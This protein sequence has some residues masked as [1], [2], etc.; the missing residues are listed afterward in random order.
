MPTDRPLATGALVFALFAGLTALMFWPWLAHLSTAL[1]GPPEDNLQDFW[2]SWYAAAAPK[3]DGFFHTSMIRYPEGVSLNYHSFAYPQVALVVALTWLFG[4]DHAT[5]VALQNLTLL[6]S[7][8]MAG[9]GAY[10]LG[11]HFGVAPL[12]ALASGFV[13]AFNPSHVAHVMHHAHVSWIG[14]IPF[15]VLSYLIAL[16]RRSRAWLA[17]SAVLYALSALSCWYYFFYLLFFLVFHTI[18]L[19]VRD[20]AWPRGFGLAAPLACVAGAVL[21]LSPLLLPMVLLGGNANAY[22]GGANLYVADV[23]GYFTFPPTHA[24]AAWTRDL[25][26]RIAPNPWEGTVYLGLAAIA[27]LIWLSWRALRARDPVLTYVLAGMITFAAFASG[28]TLHVFG[29]DLMWFHLPDIALSHLPFFANVRT[30]SRAIVM[31]YLFLSIGVGHALTLAWREH[32]QM[33]ARAAVAAASVL[34]FVDYY[35]VPRPMTDA[36]CPDELHV[37]VAPGAVLDMPYG[38][39]EGNAAMFRQ[40]CHGHPILQGNVSRKLTTSLADRLAGMNEAQRDA[41]LAK[42]NVGYIVVTHAGRIAVYTRN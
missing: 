21:L 1:I 24:L 38:Y 34:L 41:A 14:F 35:P 36:I 27:L 33:L 16:E 8:P 23:A 26:A 2:N 15:F 32:A 3:P 29:H 22:A 13:F 31:V 12:A 4:T 7:F 42:A 40:T 25:F 5:L 37:I 10:F 19:R 20:H 6:L 39:V 9:T 11:R 28:E 30:P 18:Y 17:A